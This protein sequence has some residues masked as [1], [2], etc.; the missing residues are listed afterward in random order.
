M[1]A[2]IR[3]FDFHRSAA[4]A[5]GDRTGIAVAD[6]LCWH[7]GGQRSKVPWPDPL[8]AANNGAGVAQSWHFRLPKDSVD[9]ARCRV[10]IPLAPHGKSI[11]NSA[12]SRP[13]K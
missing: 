4:H 5:H 8:V 12:T 7:L 9:L 13:S 11:G 6:N 3:F 10:G 1:L 2:Q